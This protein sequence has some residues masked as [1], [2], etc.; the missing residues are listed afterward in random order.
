MHTIRSEFER[1]DAQG[2]QA[3]EM[4]EWVRSMDRP[5]LNT[6]NF[7]KPKSEE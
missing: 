4:T 1:H 6:A 5:L 7:L 2:G 3:G